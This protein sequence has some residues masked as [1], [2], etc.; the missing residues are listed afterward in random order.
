VQKL[1]QNFTNKI[2]ENVPT[3]NVEVPVC[4]NIFNKINELLTFEDNKTVTLKV[5]KLMSKKVVIE[6]IE[7]N[8]QLKAFLKS[9]ESEHALC[10][11]RL[12]VSL[13]DP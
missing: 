13:P 8:S 12:C 11:N 1:Y 10:F 2:Q 7:N 9:E 5:V 6:F 4:T 3:Y